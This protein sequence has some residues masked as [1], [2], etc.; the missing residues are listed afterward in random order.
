[1]GELIDAL[2]RLA[3]VTR[4]EMRWEA[5]DLSQLAQGVIADLRRRTPARQVDFATAPGLVARGD[6]QL[7]RIV[8]QNLLANAWKYTSQH[9]T[10]CVQLDALERDG[11]PVYYVRDDGAGFDMI[12]VTKLFVPFQRLHDDA[13]FEGTRVGLATVQRIVRRHG[14]QHLG[15]GCGR[16]GGHLLL[17]ADGAVT[18]SRAAAQSR[19]LACRAASEQ[20][21]GI[22]QARSRAPVGLRC[23]L[24]T[25][26]LGRIELLKLY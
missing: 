23:G 7:L 1:M 22:V 3:R 14:G 2:L 5:V 13:A 18:G 26:G 9:R 12:D 19:R 6:P 15:R 16:A 25:H 10:A 20:L 8:I 4:A 11:V 17:Y 24:R 21:T